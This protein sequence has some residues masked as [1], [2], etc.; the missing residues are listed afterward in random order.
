[1]RRIYLFSVVV[2]FWLS[3]CSSGKQSEQPTDVFS[4]FSLPSVVER[5]RVGELEPMDVGSGGSESLGEPIRRRRDF[6]LTYR[7]KEGEGARFDEVKFIARLRTEIERL[8]R[9]AAVRVEGSG[10]GND[11]FNFDYSEGNHTGWVEVVGA[12]VEGNQFKL[13]GVIRE[14]TEREKK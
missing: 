3:G 10:S 7:I 1:M 4:D 5:M 12:R 9:D 11:S 6:N 14:N 8:M 13:W 2:L